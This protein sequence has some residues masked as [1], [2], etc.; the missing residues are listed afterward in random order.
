MKRKLAA[1]LSA[2]ML[3]LLCVGCSGQG[4]PSGSGSAPADSSSAPADSSS[5]PTAGEG[6]PVNLMLLS[7][8]TGV[9]AAKLL[10]DNEDGL[11]SNR[12]NATVVADNSEVAN[13]IIKG[14]VDIAALSTNM[15]ANL[16]AKTNGKVQMLAVNTLGVLYI[17][18]KNQDVYSLADLAGKTIYATGQGAN[19]EYILRHLLTTNGVDPDQDVT[20]E[21]LTP[22]EITAKMSTQKNGVCMLP[23]PAA[24][25]L[26]MKDHSIREAVSLSDAW[27][28]LDEG[29]LAMGCIVA[30]SD[31]IEEHP[32]AVATFLEEYEA[33]IHYMADEA[34]AKDASP[35]V[36]KYEI[37]ANER[38][39][40]KAIPS[41]NLTFVSGRE[42][43]DMVEQ[44]FS[45]L[46][47]ASPAAIGGAMPYDSFYYGID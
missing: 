16:S 27:D 10:A 42:M 8:P 21:W 5:A 33:S 45:V 39:A 19:P 12:Y 29:G 28:E 30:R 4:V 41:C 3:F 43:K 40:A 7:G 25:A 2:A 18:D 26:L 23:V 14:E 38:I 24:T 46:F 6:T 35:L 32:D 9:G 1:L 36:A 31:F 37:T 22:Q 13:A 47:H 15:A 20:I 34:N 11:T 17:L 44:Y